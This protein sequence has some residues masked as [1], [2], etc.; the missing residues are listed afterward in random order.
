VSGHGTTALGDNLHILAPFIVSV[1]GNWTHNVAS[2]FDLPFFGLGQVLDTVLTNCLDLLFTVSSVNFFDFIN[3]LN[4][5][6]VFLNRHLKSHVLG[7]NFAS[8]CKLV[9]ET[10]QTG[11]AVVGVGGNSKNVC[12]HFVSDLL[13]LYLLIANSKVCQLTIADIFVPP[14]SSHS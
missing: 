8:L 2:I 13:N 7:I 5:F 6:L 11:R 9:G 1:G 10:E 12:L 3:L 4:E 14:I